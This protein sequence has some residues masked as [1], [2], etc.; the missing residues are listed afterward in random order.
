MI[1][2]LLFKAEINNLAEIEKDDH[3]DENEDEKIN[4]KVNDKK[5]DYEMRVNHVKSLYNDKASIDGYSTDGSTYSE[6]TVK[7]PLTGVD[8]NVQSIIM[9]QV[10]KSCVR[11][12]AGISRAVIQSEDGG[13]AFSCE[14]LNFGVMFNNPKVSLCCQEFFLVVLIGKQKEMS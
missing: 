1:I 11:K 7:M 2:K 10:K 12:V 8:I 14:G 5:L 6:L 3:Y 4:E 13:H 9:E